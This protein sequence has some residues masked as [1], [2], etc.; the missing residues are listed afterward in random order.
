[1]KSIRS[2][3]VA[4]FF[5]TYFYIT[6][7][8]GHGPFAPP[9]IRY[10]ALAHFS[11]GSRIFLRGRQLPKYLLFCKFVCRKLHEN[12]R[13]W[14]LRSVCIPSA[15]APPRIQQWIWWG[16]FFRNVANK[17]QQSNMSKANKYQL[18]SMAHVRA[19]EAF[20]FSIIK[21]ALSHFSWHLF[22]KNLNLNSCRCINI[23]LGP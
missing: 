15:H 2:L 1:M 16:I 17:E 10:C 12:E 18:G 5:M 22:F 7:P 23:Y 6:E 11:G 21:Y 13:I 3:F 9:R 4:I 8:G 14:T 20:A 19:Q